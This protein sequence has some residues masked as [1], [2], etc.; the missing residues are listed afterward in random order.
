M[1]INYEISTRSEENM[2]SKYKSILIFNDDILEIIQRRT[3]LVSQ[4]IEIFHKNGK[5]FFFNFFTSENVNKVLKYFND[6]NNYFSTKFIFNTNNNKD[7]IKSLVNSF[8]KG[9]K[10]TYEYLLYLNKYSTRTYNDLSQYPVF[11]WLVKKHNKI[12]ELFPLLGNKDITIDFIREMKYP[13]SLQTE[14]KRDELKKS[15]NKY[16]DS[17]ECVLGTHYSTSA[18]IYFYLMRINP[19]GQSLIKLQKYKYED[20]NRMFN[21]FKEMEEILESNND[22]RELIPDIFCYI[23]YFCNLNCCYYG[24]RSDGEL[25]DDFFPLNKDASSQYFNNISSFVDFLF[26]INKLLN[27]NYM[28][29]NIMNWVDIIFGVNQLPKKQSRSEPNYNN[30]NKLTYEQNINLENDILETYELYKSGQIKENEFKGK[31][32]EI[33]GNL[34][35]VLNF[36]MTPK[37]ILFDTVDYEGRNKSVDNLPKINE[38]NSE[39]YIFF[40]KITK[41]DNFLILKDDKKSK[42]RVGIIYQNKNFIEKDIN[43]YDCNSMILLKKGNNNENI[44]LYKPHYAISYL[45]VLLDKTK[46]PIVL[47]CRYLQNYFRIQS[48]DKILNIFYED[49]VTSIKARN[50]KKEGDDFFYT[51]LMNGKLTEWKIIPYYDNLNNLNKKNIFKC[52]YNFTVKEIKHVYAHKSFI[53][54]IEIYSKQKIIITSGEDKFI[55]IRKIFDFELLTVID[56]TYSFGNSIISQTIN[57][58][59]S[60]I[61]VSDLNLLYV[62]LYDYD[63]KN[64]FIR[65]YNLNGLFFAQSDPLYFRDKK[66]ILQFNNISFTENSNLIVGFYNSNKFYILRASNLFPLYIKNIETDDKKERTGSKLVEYNYHYNEFYILYDN[67]FSIMTFKD[68]KDQNNFNSIK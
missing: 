40:T 63:S 37:Q 62:L 20:P 9:K 53:T 56:L 58:F 42:K 55:Y 31:I 45:I 61:K 50:F 18:Y 24:M 29:K 38:S 33:K 47:S 3:L 27:N 15:F 12:P 26:Y 68:Q 6:I 39:K 54:A 46:I 41:D 51:G 14:E 34:C 49:F 59:P 67:E 5:S 48:N 44:S 36:G 7:N 35:M 13:I 1:I 52:I 11:P 17:S 28:T 66:K 8:Q 16:N 2:T 32:L 4:S 23:D 57:I 65:G 21:S 43:I 30:Y 60:L 64:T 19:Y 22:N 10:L 25:V